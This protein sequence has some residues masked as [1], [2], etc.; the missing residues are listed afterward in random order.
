MPSQNRI[1]CE[2]RT[3]F[4][5][6]FATKDLA[7]GSESSSL[8]V[9]EQNSFFAESLGSPELK[10]VAQRSGQRTIASLYRGRGMLLWEGDRLDR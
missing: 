8:V 2:Q 3:E 6:S 4:F 5:K 10:A 1:G 7:F 9:A